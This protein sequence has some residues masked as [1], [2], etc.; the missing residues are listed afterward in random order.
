MA[1]EV[2]SPLFSQLPVHPPSLFLLIQLCKEEGQQDKY[3][4]KFSLSAVAPLHHGFNSPTF[5]NQ[6]RL[7]PPPFPPSLYLLLPQSVTPTRN[8]ALL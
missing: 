2:T 7:V 6:P 5:P 4:A 3:L 1:A 8:T